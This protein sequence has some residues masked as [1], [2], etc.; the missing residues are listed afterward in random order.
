[1]PK[2]PGNGWL[3]QIFIFFIAAFAGIANILLHFAVA[4]RMKVS[5]EDRASGLDKL[6]WGIEPDVEPSAERAI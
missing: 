1:M 4:E 3:D 5:E 6:Y 2:K